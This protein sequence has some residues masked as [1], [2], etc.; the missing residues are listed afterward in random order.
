MLRTAALL[1]SHRLRLARL[2]SLPEGAA[3]TRGGGDHHGEAFSLSFSAR[4][5]HRGL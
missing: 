4:A 1:R 2:A 3:A 5:R